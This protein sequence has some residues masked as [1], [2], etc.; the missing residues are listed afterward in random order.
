VEEIVEIIVVETEE[1]V[2]VEV[3]EEITEV[4]VE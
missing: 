3:E 2:E 1:A 4:V